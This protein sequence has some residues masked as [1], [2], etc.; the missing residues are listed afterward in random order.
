MKKLTLFMVVVLTLLTI[1]NQ[2]SYGINPNLRETKDER[3]MLD[4]FPYIHI[5]NWTKG[6]KFIVE[7]NDNNFIDYFLDIKEYKSKKRS[8]RITK[9]EYKDK[10][11]TVD[12]IEERTVD[13]P[14]GKCIRTYTIFDC[15]GKKFE[16]EF[17]GDRQEMANSELMTEVSD[18]IY[19]GDIEKA[20]EVLIGKK[21][22][23]ISNT[24]Y[25][26]KPVVIKDIK[27]W[28][29][30]A[31]IKIIYETSDG[32]LSSQCV[33]LSGINQLKALVFYKFQDI[34]S[35]EISFNTENS[36]TDS[37]KSPATILNPTTQNN[38][39]LIE[40]KIRDFATNEYPDD[41]KM[42]NYVY[43]KQMSAYEYMKSVNDS[44]VKDIATREYSNDYSMQKY[45][46]DKQ[47]TA[48][49]YMKN[50][51]DNEVKRFAYKEY[52][53]DYS[54]QK[55]T[56]DKQIAA[57]NYMDTVTNTSAKAKAIRE[58]PNDYSMQKYI[59]DKFSY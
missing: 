7:S 37:I 23:I 21:Y 29:S 18:L 12:T 51:T 50:V 32:K 16:F 14:R 54:M 45:T 31:P 17:I 55:Y 8:N 20:R 41:S 10:I 38:D 36:N 1:D 25:K 34:F 56:Y 9:S 15:D 43:K 42:Q 53:N 40:A 6:M 4:N 47:L 58:Y 39:Y 2:N 33:T 3:F 44:E 26:K 57:K 59:Y 13:C 27:P 49:D 35:S 30:S 22:Y 11:F 28:N 46:Y 19:Y 5:S 52:P 48:K 24:D